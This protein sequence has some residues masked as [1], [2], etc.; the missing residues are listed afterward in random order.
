MAKRNIILIVLD[1][2]REDYSEYIDIH[3]KKHGFVKLHNVITSAPW[4]LPAHA[5]MFTGLYPFRHGAHATKKIKIREIK[6]KSH[7]IVTKDLKEMGFTNYLF[8]AN[9]FIRPFFG[10]RYFDYIETVPAVPIIQDKDS[11][12]ERM[13]KYHGK[14]Q[15][16]TA[17]N[18]IKAKEY[19][20]LAKYAIR[21]I[22]IRMRPATKI[23]YSLI[24]QWPLDK[25][26]KKLIKYM[27]E[28]ELNSPF[29]LFVNLMEVHEPYTPFDRG[30]WM[31]NI[32]PVSDLKRGKIIDTWKKRYPIHA[33][34]LGKKVGDVIKEIDNKKK[35]TII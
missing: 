29:F 8:T 33:R 3:L 22:T 28:I 5:S 2:L 14:N 20:L 12:R 30:S 18:A 24:H 15:I 19:L 27:R 35:V 25:G 10:F 34:Y 31:T 17:L 1:S 7:R 23:F 9:D 4:T 16:E 13:S 26:V 32:K 6:L 11:D 21:E